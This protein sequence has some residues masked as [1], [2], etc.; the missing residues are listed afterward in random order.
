MG[1]HVGKY[2]DGDTNGWLNEKTV[3][4]LG[5]HGDSGWSHIGMGRRWSIC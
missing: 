2:M 1:R 3:G 4:V 5:G